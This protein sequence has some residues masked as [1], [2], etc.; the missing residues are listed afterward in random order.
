MQGLDLLP[1]PLERGLSAQAVS[2][3][4]KIVCGRGAN[5][6]RNGR[7]PET[8]AA[9]AAVALSSSGAVDGDAGG[10]ATAEIAAAL[11]EPDGATAT[12]AAEPFPANLP[13]VMWQFMTVWLDEEARDAAQL[14]RAKQRIFQQFYELLQGLWQQQIRRTIFKQLLANL[15]AAAGGDQVTEEFVTANSFLMY[16]GGSRA[17]ELFIESTNAGGAAAGAVNNDWDL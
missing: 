10:D 13:G 1:E 2:A 12:A 11:Q 14:R 16:Q 17:K 9:A 3:M 8:P 4:V 5:L 6:G 7:H 15:D